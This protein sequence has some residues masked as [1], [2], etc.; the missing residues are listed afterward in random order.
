MTFCIIL[1]GIYTLIQS[2]IKFVLAQFLSIS[3]GV[4]PC[5]KIKTAFSVNILNM[6]TLVLKTKTHHKANYLEQ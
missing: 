1:F 3:H 2:F 4:I 5:N 6:K